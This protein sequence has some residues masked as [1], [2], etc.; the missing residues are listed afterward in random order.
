MI[1]LSNSTAS[2][3]LKAAGV[4][5]ALAGITAIAA[6]SGNSEET[7]FLP[8][9][10]GTVAADGA[11]SVLDPENPAASIHYLPQ[12]QLLKSHSDAGT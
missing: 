10:V 6:L 11:F 8:H 12:Q 9:A 1:V 4:V 2:I 3:S 5:I 7:R